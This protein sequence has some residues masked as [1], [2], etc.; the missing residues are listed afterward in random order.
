MKIANKIT[1]SFLILGL[2]LTIASSFIFYLI[3]KD[4]L[5]ESISAH[6]ETALDSRQQHVQTYLMMLKISVGQLSRSEVLANLLII[7]KEDPKRADA[8]EIARRRLVRTKEANPSIYEFLLLDKTGIVIA[9]TD[10][11]SIGQNK[12]TDALFVGAQKE[13]YLK[14]A[15]FSEILKRPLLAV[16]SPVI[17]FQ[18]KELIGVLTARVELMDLDKIATARTGLGKTGEIYIVNKYG[19]MITPSRFRSDVFLK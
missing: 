16:S 6:L 13:T 9:S 12:S 11:A 2:I 1:Y 10:E 14:D 7:D 15:Y 4:A 18:T 19:Y 3:A 5:K 8:F 17:D